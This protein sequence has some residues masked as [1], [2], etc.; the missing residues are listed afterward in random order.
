MCP[1]KEPLA[2]QFQIT[3]AGISQ[4]IQE[5]IENDHVLYDSKPLARCSRVE[6]DRSIYIKQKHITYQMNY[7]DFL[8]FSTV[9]STALC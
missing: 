6:R 9:I 7:A 2:I 3:T 1:F 4:Q 8:T 5:I